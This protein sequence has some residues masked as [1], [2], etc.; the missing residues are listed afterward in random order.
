M[1]L[2]RRGYQVTLAEAAKEL[3]GRVTRESRLPGPGA[4]RR[5]FDS[6]VRGL[7]RRANVRIFL[8]SRLHADDVAELGIPNVF[9][10]T[11]ASWRSDGAIG[12]RC[13]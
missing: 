12:A 2:A 6:R 10:A 4:W 7:Q 8:D 5:A 3:G 9:V 13:V 11:G 1:Q